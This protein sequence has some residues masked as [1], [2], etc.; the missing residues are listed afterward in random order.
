MVQPLDFNNH[1]HTSRVHDQMKTIFFPLALAMV[2]C[3]ERP[4]FEVMRPGTELHDGNLAVT[5]LLDHQTDDIT[6]ISEDGTIHNY[7]HYG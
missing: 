4:R 5:V 2:G 6:W 3:S 1:P 7:G